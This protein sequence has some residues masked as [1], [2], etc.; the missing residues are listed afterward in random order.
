MNQVKGTITGPRYE[1]RYDRD[2]VP[3]KDYTFEVNDHKYTA[4]IKEDIYLGDGMK[5]LMSIKPGSTSE[6]LAGYCIKEGYSWGKDAKHLKAEVS[7]FEK[8]NFLQGRIT[9]KQKSTTGSVYMNRSAISNRGSKISY[10]IVMGNDEFHASRDEGEYLQVGMNIA[11]VLDKKDSIIILDRDANKYLG[12]SKPYFIIFLLVMVI[13]N[14][15]MYFAKQTP[16]PNFKMVLI[17]IDVFL[18]LATILSIAAFRATS[19]AKRFLL[20]KIG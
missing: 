17:V 7:Q 13:F 18:L 10:T 19:S 16:F 3:Y 11:V 14:G 9:E 12:L 4:Q 1:K 5:V 20:S 8:Y 2:G 6:V 15:Y